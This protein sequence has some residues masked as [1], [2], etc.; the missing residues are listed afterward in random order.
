MAFN[1]MVDDLFGY[2][3]SSA[4]RWSG[5][6]L[7]HFRG[8]RPAFSEKNGRLRDEKEVN[9]PLF[10]FFDG[11]FFEKKAGPPSSFVPIAGRYFKNQGH[12]VQSKRKIQI[13][14]LVTQGAS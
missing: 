1:W 8:N 5:R 9:C 6:S 12:T 7:D 11:R 2:K 14:L 10:V 13:R 4:L 3:S